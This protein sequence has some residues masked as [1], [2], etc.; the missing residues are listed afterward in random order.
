MCSCPIFLFADVLLSNAHKNNKTIYIIIPIK[1]N[2]I[3]NNNTKTGNNNVSSQFPK[4]TGSSPC[5]TE[6]GW[7]GYYYNLAYS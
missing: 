4:D 2:G 1:E 5:V 6:T 3:G 7:P